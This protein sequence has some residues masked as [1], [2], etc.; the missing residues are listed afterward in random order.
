MKKI[1]VMLLLVAVGIGI[2]LAVSS[3]IAPVQAKNAP[4]TGFAAVPGGLGAEARV[5]GHLG[6]GYLG[7]LNDRFSLR[8]DVRD[9]L[10]VGF[11]APADNIEVLGG[12]EL[13]L[14]K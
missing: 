14:W 1:G 4:G 3:K 10:T 8:V 6:I 5:R 7:R 12:A 13:V 2:G 11:T 9:V